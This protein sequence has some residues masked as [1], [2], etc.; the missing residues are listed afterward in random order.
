MIW[1]FFAASQRQWQLPR[2]RFRRISGIVLAL[3]LIASGCQAAPPAPTSQPSV[4]QLVSLSFPDA[5]H[6]WLAAQDCPSGR[7]SGSG[8]ACHTD[9]LKSSDGGQTWTSVSRFLLTPK[10]VQFSANGTGW[11][12]G[13]IGSSCG[14]DL[15]PNVI[16]VSSDGGKSWDRA[17]TAGGQL[18]DLAAVSP[19]NVWALDTHCTK[20]ET[21]QAIVDWSASSGQLWDNHLPPITGSAFSLVRAGPAT[22]WVMATAP[23]G[24]HAV[25]VAATSDAGASWQV[26]PTPCVGPDYRSSFTSSR[27]GWLACRETEGQQAGTLPVYQTVDGGQSWQLTGGGSLPATTE[28]PVTPTAHPGGESSGAGVGGF[29]ALDATHFLLALGDGNVLR[30]DD[31]ARIWKTVLSAGEPLS[32]LVFAGPHDGWLLA[33]T[34]VWRTTDGGITWQPV[35]VGSGNVGRSAGDRL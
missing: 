24:A 11:L 7:T 29:V 22:A 18:V 34:K 3:A 16:M 19:D 35:S 33:A 8:V 12:I 9:I 6:G 2:F 13:S 31:G 14:V 32:D 15:C 17:S 5:S 4:L 30:S 21:C 23:G 28:G 26:H 20:N 10:K 1:H 25:Q 27:A